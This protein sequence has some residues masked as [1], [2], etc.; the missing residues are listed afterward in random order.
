MRIALLWTALSGYLSASFKGLKNQN[1]E[2]LVVHGAS[3]NNAPFNSNL[4]EWLGKNR[5]ETDLRDT[6]SVLS[7]VEGFHPDVILASWHIP[8]FQT[9]CSRYR[10]RAVR[11]GCAD[12][13]WLGTLRQ[14]VGSLTAPLHLN[15]YYDAFMVAGERQAA[16]AR[17]MGYREDR[18]WRG[19]YSC[20]VDAF[21]RP[22]EEIH[23]AQ[24]RSFLYVGRL[25]EE[26]GIQAL[27]SGY[28]R[29]RDKHLDPWP[30]EIIG[31]G[32]LQSLCEGV[33]GVHVHG[34]VQPPDLPRAFMKA[35]CFVIPS[36]YEP[37]CLAI[38]EA[39]C[40][41]LPVICSNA[42]GAAAHLVQ[43]GY[44]GYL[45]ES[46]ADGVACAM[47]WV[48]QATADELTAMG[49]RSYDLSLQFSPERFGSCIV[50]RGEQLYNQTVGSPLKGR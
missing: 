5:I 23:A 16:W 24:H 14:R 30:L 26:K 8:S 34:F 3:D 38:H 18:I 13:Q 41:S 6:R 42:C 19:L 7:A 48:S 29:Y 9:L 50:N 27:I 17:K 33:P 46:D 4:F 1:T 11:V 25:V 35:S 22:P 2:L 40:S 36:R 21:R 47:G 31:K 20:D 15:R 43:D 10:D 12:N 39:T 44:N 32:S 28:C 37:W 49:R 45:I